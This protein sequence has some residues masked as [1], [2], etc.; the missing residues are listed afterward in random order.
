MDYSILINLII[1]VAILVA[2]GY[3]AKKAEI[4]T[5]ER[6]K[7][8][9][10]LLVDIICPVSI[11]ASGSSDYSASMVKNMC[12]IAV[13]AGI[14]YA[15]G[16]LLMRPISRRMKLSDQGKAIF[17]TMAV[18]GNTAFIGYPITQELY[19]NEGFVYAVIYNFFFQLYFFTYGISRISGMKQ[20]NLK[21]I[22][23]TPLNGALL[24]MLVLFLFQIKLPGVVQDTFQSVGNM[25][26]PLSMIVVG[27][28]LVGMK[29]AQILMD[30]A[31]YLVSFF[32]LLFFP[33][34]MT[35]VLKLFGIQG[36]LLTVS[37][38]LTA[39]PCGT[40]NVIFA[41]QYDCDVDFASRAV[42]QSMLLCVVTIPCILFLLSFIA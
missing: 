4:M 17:L 14:Y 36:D 15:A 12:L 19:G 33:L 38:V 3:I 11:I 22:I 6:E 30:R 1:K 7:G 20:I 2:I 21:K 26:V 40:M 23:V 28:S 18:F 37:V 9:S 34:L 32:R 41:K 5:E 31:S 42:I 16:I 35:I 13:I 29:P 39:V 8:I 10:Q 25:M 27:G 24:V